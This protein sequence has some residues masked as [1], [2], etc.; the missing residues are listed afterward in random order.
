MKTFT[1]LFV[2]VIRELLFTWAGNVNI[3]QESVQNVEFTD[4]ICI[5]QRIWL[6]TASKHTLLQKNLES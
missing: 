5:V 4:S 3:C 1:L 2:H 6:L